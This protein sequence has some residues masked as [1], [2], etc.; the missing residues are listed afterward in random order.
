M[1]LIE[2]PGS[3]IHHCTLNSPIF[4]SIMNGE[5]KLELRTYKGIRST[6]SNIKMSRRTSGI[7]IERVTRKASYYLG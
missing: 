7:K 5:A 1:T 6:G 4:T 2:Y 3:T